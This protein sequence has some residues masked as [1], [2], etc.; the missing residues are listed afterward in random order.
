[1][2][3]VAWSGALGGAMWLVLLLLPWRPWSTRESLIPG[4]EQVPLSDV[5]VLIPARDEA[6]VLPRT[7]AA[8]KA[9]GEGLEVVV[10]DDQSGDGT[11]DVARAA[12]ARVIDGTSR[13]EGW[14]GKLWALE[15]GRRQVAR[16]LILLLDADIAL[17]PGLL[18]ALLAKRSET[19]AALVSIMATLST[20]GFWERLLVPAFVYF[21]KL[22]YPFA[23]SNGSRTPIAAAAGGCILVEREALEEIGGFAAL[24]GA[25]IDDCA[26]AAAI[27]RSGRRTWIGLG[28]GVVSHRAYSG[29]APIW[30]MVSR[31]AYTQLRHSPALLALCTALMALAFWAPLIA[32][33]ALPAWPA[34][35]AASGL[36]AMMLSYQPMLRFYGHSPLWALALPLIGTL[37]LAMTWS[38]AIN[39]WR[40]KGARWKGRHYT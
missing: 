29:L 36:F 2:T 26:L 37:Y 11:G 21:F 4:P 39:S 18:A 27:K 28:H 38:S 22:L 40:G 17:A 3:V 25:L 34:A 5:T 32:L 14:S 30:A 6:A 24:S 20:A 8:L 1:M 19:A 23:L 33:P 16:P 15:Q 13:P 12:G 7:L 9:Q 35:I 10:I 31:T